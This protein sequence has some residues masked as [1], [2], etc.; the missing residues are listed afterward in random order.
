MFRQMMKS[1][2]HR[3]FVTDANI[4]YEGSISIDRDLLEAADI[5]SGEKVLIVNLDNG[6]RIESYAIP[7]ERGSGEIC[8]NGGAAKHG[9]K[10]DCVII[11]TFC[12]LDESEVKTYIPKIVKVNAKNKMVKT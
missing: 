2:I 11:I 5:L 8:L 3:A 4:D 10:G 12:T 9:K 7:A 6:A 1:K